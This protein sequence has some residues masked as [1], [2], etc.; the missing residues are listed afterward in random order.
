VPGGERGGERV[1]MLCCQEVARKIA[2]DELQE[3]SGW[4]RLWVRLHLLMCR[5]CRRYEVQLHSIGE[6][7]WKLWGPHTQDPST[8]ERLEGEIMDTAIRHTEGGRS[9]PK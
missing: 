4:Q 7:A 9:D 5:H 1:V 2:S 6:L 3:A 8:L